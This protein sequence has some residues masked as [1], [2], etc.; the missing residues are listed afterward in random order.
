VVEL[1]SAIAVQTH[2]I[3]LSAAGTDYLRL[4]LA[5]K[6]LRVKVAAVTPPLTVITPTVTVVLRND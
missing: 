2:S 5:G 6:Y 3:T 1:T 4:L